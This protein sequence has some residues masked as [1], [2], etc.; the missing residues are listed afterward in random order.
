[1]AILGTIFFFPIGDP[2]HIKTKRRLWVSRTAITI[3]SSPRK[4]VPDIA[5]SNLTRGFSKSTEAVQTGAARSPK[6]EASPRNSSGSEF[7]PWT[8]TRQGS[9]GEEPG[10]YIDIGSSTYDRRHSSSPVDG[11]RLSEK[12]NIDDIEVPNPRYKPP[13]KSVQI[14]M[15]IMTGGQGSTAL[16]LT[17]KPLL[18]AT[19]T[20]LSIYQPKLTWSADISQL[21]SLV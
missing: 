9:P 16:G 6:I 7:S 13:P 19:D 3:P 4:P 21:F 12:L 18:Y 11:Q 5:L 20:R 15:R 8:L 17:G 1:M 10:S 2:S 14:I